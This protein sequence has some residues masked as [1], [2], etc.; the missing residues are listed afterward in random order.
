[1]RSMMPRSSKISCVRG[2]IPL[3]AS[4]EK[5][6][7]FCR[8]AGTERIAGWSNGPSQA[9]VRAAPYWTKLGSKGS[10]LGYRRLAGGCGTWAACWR[11]PVSGKRFQEALGNG[12]DVLSADGVTVLW[13]EQ[14]QEA[15]PGASFRCLAMPAPPAPK[16]P[17]VFQIRRG[18][19]APL[20]DTDPFKIQSSRRTPRSTKRE[21]HV[22][23]YTFPAAI[24]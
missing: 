6:G 9:Q 12:D 2:C 3:H 5:G 14:T 4:P 17:K 19:H 22:P 11:D 7:P 16:A 23:F 13:W 15:A 21:R 20:N 10:H 24:T 1:M 8:S 18:A